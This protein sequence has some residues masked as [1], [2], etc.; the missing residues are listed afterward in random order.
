MT[1]EQPTPE[2]L[3][4]WRSTDDARERMQPM[5]GVLSSFSLSEGSTEVSYESMLSELS[6]ERG[7][8]FLAEM[9]PV[10]VAS[11][12][13]PQTV[14]EDAPR[15]PADLS[16]TEL[17]RAA[18]EVVSHATQN[19]GQRRIQAALQAGVKGNPDFPHPIPTLP[20]HQVLMFLTNGA[21][22]AAGASRTRMPPQRRPR[23]ISE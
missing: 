14:H 13:Q 7:M 17:R 22:S 4:A 11:V 19:V 8:A 23:N 6:S 21:E 1:D 12:V 20:E 2:E 3:L 16:N 18:F 9:L 5:L 15:L 10:F